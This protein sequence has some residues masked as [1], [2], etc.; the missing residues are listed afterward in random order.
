MRL[1]N[2]EAISK[3]SEIQKQGD[4]NYHK[5]YSFYERKSESFKNEFL[6]LGKCDCLGRISKPLL[7]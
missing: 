5:E 4:W 7:F 2:P 1:S 3:E 6:Y